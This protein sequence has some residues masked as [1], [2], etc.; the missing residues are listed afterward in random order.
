MTA[1]Q[2]QARHRRTYLR[3]RARER[4]VERELTALLRRMKRDLEQRRIHAEYVEAM[5]RPAVNE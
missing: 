3:Q 1:R 2:Q 4:Q 5:R